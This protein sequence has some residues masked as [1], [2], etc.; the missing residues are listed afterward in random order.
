MQTRSKS[1]IYKFNAFTL[2][3][4]D[5]SHSHIETLKDPLWRQVMS[6]ENYA[7]RKNNLWHL[8]PYDSS[9]KLLGT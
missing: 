8:V 4:H 9:M 6:K 5:K 7:L 2:F 1:G 3:S